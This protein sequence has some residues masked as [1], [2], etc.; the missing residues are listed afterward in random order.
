MRIRDIHI[1]CEKYES[2]IYIMKSLTKER[3]SNFELLRI[4]AMF[5]IV[6]SHF[7]VH[8]VYP[9]WQRNISV[10]DHFNNLVATLF[11]TGNI[12][13]TLF[14]LLTGYFSCHQNFNLRKLFNIY[15]KTLFF[16]VLILGLFFITSD[17]DINNVERFIF[18]FTHDSYWFITCWLLLYSFSPLLNTILKYVSSKIIQIYL[19]LGG[20]LWIVSPLLGLGK[21]GYS[22]LIWFMYLYILGAGIRLNY[23]T[24]LKQKIF[25]FC[26]LNLFCF[27]VVMLAM[28]IYFLPQK[29][30]LYGLMG[31]SELNRVY[32][33]AISL[34]IFYLFKNIKIKS[35]TI[36]WLASSM[37]SVYLL[38]DND[39]VRHWLWKMQLNVSVSMNSVYFIACSIFVS[40][41][42]FSL[43]ILIDKGLY[44]IYN[45]CLIYIENKLSK[46]KLL[47]K[48]FHCMR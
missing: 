24:F 21:N 30:S 7:V 3:E 35:F 38:H 8:G 14:V 48:Y 31:Y 43:C 36:N 6:L 28:E 19:I 12:G 27:I 20:L 37:F 10:L 2:R 16:S 15:L 39:L 44:L 26:I 17:N 11:C 5:L 29:I 33:L 42:V 22:N 25:S 1:I 32:T 13:V 47:H 41:A 23:L 45:P 40:L 9:Y 18:P 4:F 46:I 34:W